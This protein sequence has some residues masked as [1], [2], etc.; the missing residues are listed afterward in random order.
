[1]RGIM[2]FDFFGS[3]VQ[4]I[5][6][7][8]KTNFYHNQSNLWFLRNDSLIVHDVLLQEESKFNLPQKNVV[9]F[10]FYKSLFYLLTREKLYIYALGK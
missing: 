3:Y 6:I 1:M 4:T 7:E 8:V 10:A 5:N 9:D 2:Q